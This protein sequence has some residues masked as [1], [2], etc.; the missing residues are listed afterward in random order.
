MGTVYLSERIGDEF[1]QRAAIKIIRGTAD[2]VLLRRFQDERRILATLD[3]PHIAR[4][5]DGGASDRGLPYVAME[6]VDGQPI[7]VYCTAQRLDVRQRLEVF[8]LTCL[9]VHYAHQHLVIHRDLKASN[10]LVTADGTPK[11]LDFGIA[12]ILERDSPVDTTRTMFRLLTPESASPE[13]LRGEAITTATDVYALGVLLYRLLTGNSPYRAATRTESDLMRAVCEETPAA[14]SVAVRE[15]DPSRGRHT[16][17]ADLDR[18]VLMALRKEPERRYSSAEQFAE[19]IR[20]YFE[21]RPVLAAPDSTLYRVRKFAARNRVAVAAAAGFLLAVVIGIGTTTWQMRVAHQERNRAQ[22]EFNAVKSL[23]TSVLGELHDAVARVPGTLAAREL[24]IRRATQYLEALRPDAAEDAALRREL[25]FGYKR[26]AQVQG[27][28]G[29]PNLGDRAAAR[30]GLEQAAAL[31]EALPEP[32]DA[33]AGV[34]LAETYLALHREGG[35]RTPDGPYRAKAEALLN[36]FL[37][38][39]P[40]NPRV[41]ATAASFW[42]SI[43]NDQETAKDFE[44]ALGSIL[45]MTRAAEAWLALAPESPDASRTLSLAYKKAGTEQVMLHRADDALASY[46]KAAALDRSRVEREPS[47]GL[48][49]MDL[50]FAYGGIGSALEAQGQTER[51]LAQY[52]Q[53]VELRRT[54][55][56]GD[57][58]DDFA[59]TALARGHERVA[60]L[61][62]R[63]GDID[64]ALAAEEARIAVLAARRSA[65]PDRAAAWNDEASA[66]FAAARRSL[67]LLESRS[68]PIER[69]QAR[70]VRAMFDRVAA[71]QAEWVRGKR[72]AAL[73]PPAQELREATARC[74]RL[75][76]SR[77]R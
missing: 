37:A 45:N 21:G 43:A 33:D 6:Y 38:V 4:L 18:V 42:F 2:A 5:I 25:A 16:V 10:I 54:V 9:A 75:L 32:L 48:W 3:H 61:L 15:A 50:S 14:P 72:S 77:A 74:D 69:A 20:R 13:Q 67:E 73:P 47:R 70:H 19:D 71:L 65:H 30:R 12:K 23:A 62:G 40:S 56:A 55:V 36:R 17:D 51:A 63:L 53:A 39:A 7:D 59:Q 41:Q 28:A 11:L 26:L 34:G 22:R 46:E 49:R 66:T 76:A 8:R 58:D 27:Q 57:P 29:F 24:L 68:G 60:F 64:G 44:R 31:F 1:S 35:G 52:R